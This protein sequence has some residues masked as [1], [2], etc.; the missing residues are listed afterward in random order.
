MNSEISPKDNP[1]FR[2][3]HATDLHYEAG[4]SPEIP[5]ANDRIRCFIRDINR[6]DGSY[7]LNFILLSGDLTNRGAAV[8]HELQ[9]AAK[10]FKGLNV[11][12]HAVAGNHDFAPSRSFAANYPG[13]EDYHEG[14]FESSAFANVFGEAGLKFSFEKE[15]YSF[16]G[17]S[18]RENDPD[19]VLPWL[20]EEASRLK[21]NGI[22]MGHY[23]LYP[24]RDE[25]RLATWGF[26]RINSSLPRLREI[27]DGAGRKILLYLHG[28]DHINSVRNRC[29]TLHVSGGGI[30]KGCT[31][32]RV[33]S[34]YRD[35]IEAHFCLISDPDLHSFNYWGTDNPGCCV[36]STH[37]TVEEYHRGNAEEQCFT[38]HSYEC[39]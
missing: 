26:G 1:L 38:V 32:Y 19:G 3:V 35:R 4:R 39:F 2:F 25:G 17:F 36:D 11:P 34:C 30:Q 5:E 9:E 21:G 13:K 27:I 22:F 31:G 20:A 8:K 12:F 37:R 14:P 24:A 6:L 18:L 33:F 15:G 23:G 7:P 28:H 10:L 16:I 29:G